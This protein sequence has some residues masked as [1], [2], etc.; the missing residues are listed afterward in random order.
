MSQW[1][2]NALSLYIYIYI[3]IYVYIYLNTQY[4]SHLIAPK[5]ICALKPLFNYC[6]SS[7][8]QLQTP[9]LCL[10]LASP[11]CTHTQGHLLCLG[12]RGVTQR[13]R[14]NCLWCNSQPTAHF[15]QRSLSPQQLYLG[16]WYT[17]K[18]LNAS[19]FI[20]FLPEVVSSFERV[21][22][23]YILHTKVEGYISLSPRILTEVILFC[24]SRIDLCFLIPAKWLKYSIMLYF[25][26][27]VWVES[28]QKEQWPDTSMLVG[29]I[30]KRNAKKLFSWLLFLNFSLKMAP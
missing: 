11:P 23:L 24:D 16:L 18:V 15:C 29:N 10:S 19:G 28:S 3:Y 7:K 27:F 22:S 25:D 2:S 6:H 8:L 17:L 30:P 26:S 12:L 4:I 14:A 13:Q 21:V 1:Q 9:Q 5:L 20:I